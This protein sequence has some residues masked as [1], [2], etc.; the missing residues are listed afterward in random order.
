MANGEAC[1]ATV[2]LSNPDSVPIG[3][4]KLL[5]PAGNEYAVDLVTLTV[6]LNASDILVHDGNWT[7]MVEGGA[8]YPLTATTDVTELNVFIA[9]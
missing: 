7:V 3:T 9:R 8:S 2:T 5:D 1:E 6:S 4:I